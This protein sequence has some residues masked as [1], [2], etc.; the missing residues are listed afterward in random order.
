MVRGGTRSDAVERMV[1]LREGAGRQGAMRRGGW[2][3]RTVHGSH[4]G[5]SRGCHSFLWDQR[6]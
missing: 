3:R 1:A 4:R 5:L 2:A 6:G